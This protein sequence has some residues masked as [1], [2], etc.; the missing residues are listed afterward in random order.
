MIRVR[1]QLVV[2]IPTLIAAAVASGFVIFDPLGTHR[3]GVDSLRSA[4]IANATGAA[5]PSPSTSSSATAPKQYSAE[6][7]EMSPATAATPNYSKADTES[8][9]RTLPAIVGHFSQVT[10]ASTPL[11]ELM[12]VTDR[13]PIDQPTESGTVA[14]QSYVA[15]VVTYSGTHPV[16][17]GGVNVGPRPDPSAFQCD[18]VGVRNAMT[19]AWTK[20]FQSCP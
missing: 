10:A 6:G 7:L 15:W 16:L 18:L 4:V 13:Q 2:A 14:P 17:Y 20:V 11:T 9:F 12:T 19:G 1:T 8:A 5:T 3:T